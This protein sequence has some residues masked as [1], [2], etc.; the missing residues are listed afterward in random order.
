MLYRDFPAQMRPFGGR[1]LEIFCY[2]IPLL[3]SLLLILPVTGLLWI[4]IDG[5]HSLTLG[6]GLLISGTL[7]AWALSLILMAFDIPDRVLDRLRPQI[8]RNQI[9]GV[10]D[11]MQRYARYLQAVVFAGKG[12]S[13]VS[14]TLHYPS[15]PFAVTR[16]TR[17]EPEFN[18]SV[19]VYDRAYIS[20]CV[21]RG[22]L[23]PVL[24]NYAGKLGLRSLTRGNL[25]RIRS[26][27][28]GAFVKEPFDPISAHERLELL[29]QFGA[30][31]PVSRDLAKGPS[32][33]TVPEK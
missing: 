10:D 17:L 29:D 32:Q 4:R 1:R 15:L 31:D 2:F 21:W 26:F 13:R 30:I 27:N 3:A 25:S 33:P 19:Y 24:R 23:T 18:G 11:H 28:D 22:D 7:M 6:T 14:V 5:G 8:D 16:G 12:I 9:A 20:R